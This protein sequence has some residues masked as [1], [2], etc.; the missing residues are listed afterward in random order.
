MY[1]NKQ[2][3]YYQTWLKLHTVSQKCTNFETVR[4][5][6]TTTFG[7]NIQKTLE[8]SLHVSIFM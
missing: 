2:R 4:L 1:Y 3:R 6:I 8:Q 7:R 5:K